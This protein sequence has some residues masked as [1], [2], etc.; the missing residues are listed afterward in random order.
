MG[1]TQRIFF[2]VCLGLP[3]L[4]IFLHTCLRIL[5]SIHKF[6]MPQFLAGLIDNSLRHRLQPPD[7][8]AVRHGIEPGMTVLEVG[9]GS[10]TYMLAAARRVG[11]QGKVVA[12]DIE[13]K[14]I[15][16]LE[17][18]V[19]VEGVKNIEARLADVY[20]LPFEDRYF[21]LIYLITVIGEI[22]HPVAAMRE[23][24]RVL[25]PI[26]TLVFSELLPDPDYPLAGTL[27]RM[28]ESA[29]FNLRRRI[30]NF[31]HYTLIFEK[32]RSE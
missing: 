31:F 11:D 24:N 32:Q 9:P 8:T 7:E 2:Y 5:R 19:R 1:M 15:A 4:L 26:G 29:G 21:D 3:I 10:G 27:N 13:P 18:R 28:A 30:G 12:V 25:S 16:R 17:R 23:F 6:P 22:P 20:S 14:I